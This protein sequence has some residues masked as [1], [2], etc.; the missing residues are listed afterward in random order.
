MATDEREGWPEKL[1]AGFDVMGRAEQSAYIILNQVKELYESVDGHA[2]ALAEVLDKAA[3]DI[4]DHA[5]TR[6]GLPADLEHW[7]QAG[8][9]KRAEFEAERARIQAEIDE[10]T[11]G[12]A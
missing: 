7:A 2:P 11:K 3:S 5:L 9:D 8:K 1:F 12:E 6:A 4:F 10:L